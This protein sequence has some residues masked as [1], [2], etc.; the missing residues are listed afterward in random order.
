MSKCRVPEIFLGAFVAVALF[1]MGYVVASSSQ[2]SSPPVSSPTAEQTTKKSQN[3]N[4]TVES[5]D[6]VT[7]ANVIIAVFTGLLVWTAI[8]QNRGLR[9]ANKIAT[10]ASNAVLALELPHLYIGK[11]LL[12]P[13]ED[14]LTLDFEIE[15]VG[16]TP[17]IVTEYG[18]QLEFMDP[19]PPLPAY[20][21]NAKWTV[22][23]IA[24]YHQKFV[25]RTAFANAETKTFFEKIG[26]D[27]EIK[28]IPTLYFFG[29]FKYADIFG[30]NR[31]MGFAYGINPIMGEFRRVGG[32]NWNYERPENG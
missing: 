5:W 11:T 15:N 30:E 16:R 26:F 2:P 10:N 22:G 24:I 12:K 7:F 14:P 17:A 6:A 19:F 21:P 28:E 27:P 20:D 3:K 9:R 1:A 29:Y 32:K 13:S 31:V 4:P 18:V 23:D 8:V 25:E